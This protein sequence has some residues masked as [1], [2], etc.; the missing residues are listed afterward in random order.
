MEERKIGPT[1]FT[2]ISLCSARSGDSRTPI[3]RAIPSEKK[4]HL[5]RCLE[6]DPGERDE[7]SGAIPLSE[8]ATLSFFKL[9][10]RPRISPARSNEVSLNKIRSIRSYSLR[11]LSRNFLRKD[12]A[13]RF[14]QDDSRNNS[15]LFPACGRDRCRQA[16]PLPAPP[17]S[18]KCGQIN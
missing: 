9:T 2:T 3:A 8:N 4:K 12:R 7:R 1:S 18:R 14:P 13:S 10:T 15:R 6:G 17:L 11:N 5:Y 16:L